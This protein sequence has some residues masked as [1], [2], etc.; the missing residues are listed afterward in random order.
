MVAIAHQYVYLHKAFQFPKAGAMQRRALTTFTKITSAGALMKLAISLYPMVGKVEGIEIVPPLLRSQLFALQP[1]Q[2]GQQ[3]LERLE[4]GQVEREVAIE[5]AMARDGLERAAVQGR[6]DAQLSNAERM[7]LADVVIDNN[8]SLQAMLAQ[9]RRHWE[10][11]RAQPVLRQP[12]VGPQVEL[13]GLALLHP[14]AQLHG[15]V[16]IGPGASVWPYVVMRSEV[17]HIRIGARTNLQ[18]FVMVHVGNDTPTIVGED[19]SITHHVT[20]HGCEIGDRCLIGINSTI[21][22]GAK[23]GANSIVAGHAIVMQNQVFPENSIIAGV[24]AKLIGTRDNGEANVRNAR[25]YEEIARRL[26][27]GEERLREN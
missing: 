7:A 2:A 9:V 19:C 5:R 20:L 15:K 17:H 13:E 8:G 26:V 1:R 23:I 6:L 24:P 27:R 14:T 21:M 12:H 18:D 10:R 3:H 16:W 22:D 11:V 4:R 25:F